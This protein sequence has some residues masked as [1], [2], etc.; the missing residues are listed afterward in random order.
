MPVGS[1]LVYELQT[2]L[3][4]KK[5]IRTDA[6]SLKFDTRI[7]PQGGGE[8][9]PWCA[10]GAAARAAGGRPPGAA[11]EGS[12]DGALQCGGCVETPSTE[13]RARVGRCG[14][15]IGGWGCCCCGGG[16]RL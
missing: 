6:K 5:E 9:S 8:D 11:R 3:T 16:R 1:V 15:C 13:G 14:G 4:C 7:K 2:P 12:C 10:R